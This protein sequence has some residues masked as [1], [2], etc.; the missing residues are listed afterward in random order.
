[1]FEVSNVSF[2]YIYIYIYIYMISQ[3]H[4][5]HTH[6]QQKNKNKIIHILWVTDPWG[7]RQWA[8]P[9]QNK[10]THSQPKKKKKNPFSGL[11]VTDPQQT[12][13][14]P[15][16]PRPQNPKRKNREKGRRKGKGKKKKKIL[17]AIPI[18]DSEQRQAR[19]EVERVRVWETYWRQEEGG[20]A[21]V[22]GLSVTARSEQSRDFESERLNITYFFFYWIPLC[23]EPVREFK[24]LLENECSYSLSFFLLSYVWLLRESRE[25]EICNSALLFCNFFMGKKCLGAHSWR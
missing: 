11:W 12:W 20:G 5:W 18:S 9:Q 19:G 25:Y 13:A 8:T 4:I 3:T 15:K 2:I 14:E 10:H 21:L 6:S 16:G 23:S 17:L 7:P 1:M 24:K 22:V